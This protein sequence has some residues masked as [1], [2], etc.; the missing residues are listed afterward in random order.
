MKEQLYLYSLL[1]TAQ[2][3]N[4]LSE[5][6][7]EH[8]FSDVDTSD[9][10]VILRQAK[11]LVY[12]RHN[13]GNSNTL[14][15]VFPILKGNPDTRKEIH[16]HVLSINNND[17][18][19]NEG[20]LIDN[21]RKA[22]LLW[23]SQSSNLS[24]SQA[25]ESLLDLQRFYLS[26]IPSGLLKT[27]SLFEYLKMRAA[28]AQC[29]SDELRNEQ[30]PFLLLCGDVSGIQEFI[31]DIHSS[32][33]GRSIKGRSFFLQ[34]MVDSLIERILI[35]TGGTFANIIYSSGGKFYILLPNTE[36][37]TNAIAD[38]ENV[39]VKKLWE[40]YEGKLYVCLGF[41]T[42]NL[43]N[44][45]VLT[46]SDLLPD[47]SIAIGI[48]DIWKIVSD[49]A[50]QKKSRRFKSLLVN[51]LHFNHLFRGEWQE[52]YNGENME[53]CAVTG[54]PVSDDLINILTFGDEQSEDDIIYVKSW[55]KKQVDLGKALQE[56]RIVTTQYLPFKSFPIPQQFD[57]T[58]NWHEPIDLCVF[59][60]I[61]EQTNNRNSNQKV[62]LI[63]PNS[64][65]D[66]LRFIKETGS[67]HFT[68]YGGN[69][70]P[71]KKHHRFTSEFVLQDL[72]DLAK[73]EEGKKF[74]KIAVLRMDID[75]L[76][77]VFTNKMQ[78]TGL[79]NFSEYA[80]LSSSLDY[81]FSG[82][83]NSIRNSEAFNDY[84]TLQ[85]SGGDDL[86]VVG[87][88]DKTIAFAEKVQSEFKKLVSVEGDSS[89]LSI[90]AGIELF[91]P[92]FPIVK[93]ISEAGE[94][95][96]IAKKF[97]NKNAVY[98]LGESICWDKEWDV[99][100]KLKEYIVQ[101]Y[102]N[103]QLP[104]SIFYRI[105]IY[106]QQKDEKQMQWFWHSAYYFSKQTREYEALIPLKKWLFELKSE[107]KNENIPTF[108]NLYRHL[109]LMALAVKLADYETR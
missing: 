54:R 76:G 44:E 35:E 81:F 51:D 36:G 23:F 29:L 85:Y 91:S 15:S 99:V 86:C 92:K 75:D 96:D 107:F 11:S 102:E 72:T 68:F 97:P 20:E 2:L 66:Y 80:T 98:L 27:V 104:K 17:S 38:I 74:N 90:S 33:A 62:K 78:E 50:A 100:Q 69:Q 8:F 77:D 49:K 45:Y 32:K 65:S 56:S 57:E 101:H 105:L 106:K 42:F 84:I 60:K 6:L 93:A 3:G 7:I 28:F 87:R 83:L 37:V 59:Q 40:E 94:A 5:Q 25:A 79:I 52:D 71:T 61:D 13:E 64:E 26:S 31:Y 70:S 108:N 41:T 4:D 58:S 43:T 53:T 47:G 21:Y 10:D 89:R 48:N 22:I 9:F 34:L 46:C 55:V 30:K 103:N 39:I 67:T 73:P 1:K 82:V 12:K 24:A 19:L 109:D 14:V 88:W 18:T 16:P 95:L 63:N